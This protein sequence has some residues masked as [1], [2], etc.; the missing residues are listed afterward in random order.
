MKRLFIIVSALFLFVL[1]VF[2]DFVEGETPVWVVNSD[3]AYGL[4]AGEW[5]VDFSGPVTYGIIDGL[6]VGTYFWLWIFQMPSVYAKWNFIQETDAFP[7][8]A[9]GG[10]FM[11]Y[12]TENESKTAK[13]TL[14]Y[15]NISGY[16]SKKLS[17]N[18]YL[19]GSYT[20][21]KFNFSTSSSEFDDHV[22]NAL[23]DIT[24]QE[25]PTSISN[26]TG[27]LIYQMSKST[28]MLLEASGNI[29]E[30][31]AFYMSPGFEWALGDMFRLKLAVMTFFGANNFYWPYLNMRLRFK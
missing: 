8:F 10:K 20:Y 16:V 5:S 26:I 28:R 9:V 29:Y 12:S 31:T 14:Q 24:G 13:L 15:F 21:N 23:E 2:A 25:D 30:K 17:E 11:Q 4:Q 3:T 1:C 6:Q 27:S 18:L 19:T 7:A 22:I